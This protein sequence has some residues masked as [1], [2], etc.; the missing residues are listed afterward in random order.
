MFTARNILLTLLLLP[1]AAAMAQEGGDIQAQIDYAYQTE[2]S[3]DL[4]NLIQNLTTQVKSNDADAALRYH[5]AHAQYG[6]GRL[7]K[8]RHAHEAEAALSD[9]IDELKPAA[10]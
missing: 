4:T 7:N 9:C 5:L 10:R 8:D 1:A 3:N 6:F 2:D